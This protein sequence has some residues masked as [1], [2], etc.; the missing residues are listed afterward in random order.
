MRK[1]ISGWS[2]ALLL[3]VLA[4]PVNAQE[5][6]KEVP[7]DSPSMLTLFRLYDKGVLK[8]D[9]T[10]TVVEWLRNPFSRLSRHHTRYEFAVALMRVFRD[11][12]LLRL[13]TPAIEDEDRKAFLELVTPFTRELHTLGE[14][15]HLLKA[16]FEA[17]GKG[18]LLLD[19]ALMTQ[20]GVM[21]FVFSLIARIG[22][23]EAFSTILNSME[24][25]IWQRDFVSLDGFL[26]KH[27]ASS[28][29]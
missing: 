2:L 4:T 24:Q 16:R 25:A 7:K 8:G 27:N 6:M 21:R 3:F 17:W 19:N 10:K 29:R 20:L 14:K 26:P 9:S 11:N 1:R 23:Y 22:E 15:T 18:G 28:T 13:D 12:L 5:V